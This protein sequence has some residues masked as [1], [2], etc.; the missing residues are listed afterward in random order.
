MIHSTPIVGAIV[1]RK[2]TSSISRP[3]TSTSS[4]T[5]FPVV[6]HRSKSAFARN[7]EE[8]R[9]RQRITPP[10]G[11]LDVPSI[12]HSLNDQSNSQTRDVAEPETW[13]DKI[14]KEN[15]KRVAGMDDAEREEERRQILERFG[16]N[17]GDVL[18]RARLARERQR[19]G[20]THDP[21]HI[22]QGL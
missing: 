12:V 16:T 11:L 7:R 3:S 5:G 4:R 15:E 6:Q 1:E 22:N 2:T 20:K 14:S 18:K 8:K 19:Q 17:I 10:S 21:F 9:S 13:R